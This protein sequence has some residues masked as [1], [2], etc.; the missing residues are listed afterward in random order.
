MS[1]VKS[2]PKL[3]QQ[4]TIGMEITFKSPLELK[5]K[6]TK[7]PKARE[8]ADNQVVIGFTF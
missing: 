6:R 5:A 8:K 4:P 7:Q 3:F 2:Q 1:V